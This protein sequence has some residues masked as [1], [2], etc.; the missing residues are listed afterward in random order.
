MKSE[1]NNMIELFGKLQSPEKLFEK[2]YHF[3][4]GLGQSL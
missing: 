1:I 4:E 2:E 3:D